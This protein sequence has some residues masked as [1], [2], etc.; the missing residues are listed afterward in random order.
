M[1]LLPPTDQPSE[2][3]P[4]TSTVTM[5]AACRKMLLSRCQ[6]EFEKKGIPIL[7]S[8]AKK[9]AELEALRAAMKA[10]G[11]AQVN[12]QQKSKQSAELRELT[13][14]L[15]ELQM[16][17][18]KRALGTVKFIGELFKLKMLN[19]SIMFHCITNLIREP[20]DEEGIECLAKLLVTIGKDLEGKAEVIVRV[21]LS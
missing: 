6:E 17:A 14:D 5:G 15:N 8:I 20:D 12:E 11:E 21:S 7:E 3:P 4:K 2:E 9:G 19:E 18:K 13:E 10:T 1:E 16:K